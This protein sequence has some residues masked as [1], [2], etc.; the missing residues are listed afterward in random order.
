MTIKVLNMIRYKRNIRG[1]RKWNKH[2]SEHAGFNSILLPS[3]EELL[4]Q[5]NRYSRHKNCCS[6]FIMVKTI[7]IT[8]NYCCKCL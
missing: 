1:G 6:Y 8:M 2:V 4:Y 5:L 3:S 7:R